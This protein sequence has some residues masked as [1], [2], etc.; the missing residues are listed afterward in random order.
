MTTFAGLR[1]CQNNPFLFFDL[2]HPFSLLLYGCLPL[3]APCSPRNDYL[4]RAVKPLRSGEE[5]RGLGTRR[6]PLRLAS[7]CFKRYGVRLARLHE[8]WRSTVPLSILHVNVKSSDRLICDDRAIPQKHESFVRAQGRVCVYMWGTNSN[9]WTIG[10][11]H[12]H[13]LP[14]LPQYP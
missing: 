10:L 7:L 12:V 2:L 13:A 6:K 8:L 5:S 4:E 14:A 1:T 9:A 3:K 11:V